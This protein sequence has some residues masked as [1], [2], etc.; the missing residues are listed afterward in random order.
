MRLFGLSNTRKRC[1]DE[2]GLSGRQ[3]RMGLK[4]VGTPSSSV[5]R[6]PAT[7]HLSR[8]RLLLEKGRS[9]SPGRE[10]PFE[11][12]E[13]ETIPENV[14]VC[15]QCLK[16]I[17]DDTQRISVDGGHRHTFANPHGLVYEIGCFQTAVGCRGVGPRSDEFTWFRGFSW[18]VVICGGCMTHLGWLFIGSGEDGFYGIILERLARSV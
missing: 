9:D 18:Q 13:E 6:Y 7:L 14:L 4:T 10:L 2:S 1:S 8:L 12:Q 17:T 15:R 5:I 16:H 3:P 11:D